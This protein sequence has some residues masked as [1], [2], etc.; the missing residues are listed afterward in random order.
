[1]NFLAL[2]Y[3]LAVGVIIGL[4]RVW[5][6]RDKGEGQRFAGLRTFSLASLLGGVLPLLDDVLPATFILVLWVAV[7][8]SITALVVV[9]H[10]LEARQRADFGLTTELAL[11]LT[12]LLGSLCTAG[13]VEIAVPVAVVTALLLSLKPILHGWLQRLQQR[14]LFAILQMLLISVVLLPLLPNRGMGPGEV[15]NPYLVGWMVVLITGI[16]FLGYFAIKLL[17]SHRGLLLTGML[18]GLASSTAVTLTLSRLGKLQAHG[19]KLFVAAILLAS[20]TMFPRMLIEVAV[21]NTSVLNELLWPLLAMMG[22][23]YL[24]VFYLIQSA[25]QSAHS[26]TFALDNPFDIVTALKFSALL[27]AILL[28]AHY[29]H[30]H[31]DALGIYAVAAISGLTDVDAITLSLAK[32]A[33]N[34]LATSVAV[35]AILLAASV[36]TAVKMGMVAMLAHPSMRVSSAAIATLALVAGWVTWWWLS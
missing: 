36:N 2:A 14:E 13:F 24:G 31:F 25:R 29:A 20:G 6:Q 21:L 34:G 15:L 18:G 10:L 7:F 9:A 19:H 8:F 3:A 11:L 4:E 33:N 12:F 28:V 5:S 30:A 32:M 16:S 35:P 22:V 27:V 26:V 23:T 17:G 1:M